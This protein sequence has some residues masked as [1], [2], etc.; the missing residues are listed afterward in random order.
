[1]DVNDLDDIGALI[2]T[3]NSTYQNNLVTEW[4][5]EFSQLFEPPEM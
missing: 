3:Q 1:M 5:Y 4:A 2:P